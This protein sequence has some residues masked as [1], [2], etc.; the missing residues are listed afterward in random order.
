MLKQNVSPTPRF[1]QSESTQENTGTAH[2]KSVS[3]ARQPQ[4]LPGFRGK[5]VRVRLTGGQPVVGI[6]EGYNAYEILLNVQGQKMLI[7]K[8]SIISIEPQG[9]TR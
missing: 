2:D 3:Q 6:L 8:H 4:F 9:V 1:E 7:F 5:K